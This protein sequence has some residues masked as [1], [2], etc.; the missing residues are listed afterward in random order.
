MNTNATA[1]RWVSTM[2]PEQREEFYLAMAVNADNHGDAG[3]A[4]YWL[5]HAEARTTWQVLNVKE[6]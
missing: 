2:S 5:A 1:V 4:D 6:N 3:M